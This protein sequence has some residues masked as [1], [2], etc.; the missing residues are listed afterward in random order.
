VWML[1]RIKRKGSSS[2][3][4]CAALMALMFAASSICSVHA[5]GASDKGKADGS[6]GT[7]NF[8][9]E[10]EMLTYRALES[11]GAAIACDVAA[12]LNGT[13]PSFTKFTNGAICAVNVGPNQATVLLLPFDSSQF[14]DFQIWRADMATMARLHDRA[15]ID[16]PLESEIIDEKGRGSSVATSK[17]STAV[18]SLVSKTPAGP[19]LAL[20]QG[21]LAL[22]ASEQSTSS[23]GGTI[24]DQAF[25][26]SV[27]RELRELS[28]P[29]LMPTAYAANSLAMLDK[30]TSPFLTSL[31]KIL[32]DRDECLRSLGTIGASQNQKN[33]QTTGD[34]R[35]TR[36]QRM[37]SDVDGFLDTLTDGPVAAPKTQDVKSTG[38]RAPARDD[39]GKQNSAAISSSPSYSHLGAVLLADGL[40]AK[41]GF[42]A[43]KGTLS[44]ERAASLHILLIKAL[45]SGGSVARLSNVFGTTIKYS[46]GSVGTFALFAV[47]GNLECS[48]NVYEYGGTLKAEDFQ[49]ALRQYIPDPT[50]QM[51]FLRHGC[52]RP[53][54]SR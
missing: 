24:H 23:V 40:A 36:M 46:G 9:I 48:G 3:P 20:A 12:Y 32:T 2:K 19:P 35:A 41:M 18:G 43:D 11:N 45:E 22:M 26:D 44:A 13:D 53:S 29:V 4:P 47:D 51:V 30:S 49:G 10:T 52:R 28:V 27:G 38:T 31:D 25:M 1:D 39:D 15:K 33:V 42:D 21:V 54:Q 17:A 8:S 5:Q 6:S 34:S 37:L 50:K 7:S 16:C 14:A